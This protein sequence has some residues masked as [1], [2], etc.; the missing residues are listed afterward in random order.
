[1][2]IGFERIDMQEGIMVEVLLDSGAIELVLSSE[3]AKKQDFN[4]KDQ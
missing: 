4:W 3:F 2:K 1:V